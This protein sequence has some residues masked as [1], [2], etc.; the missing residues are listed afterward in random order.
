[1]QPATLQWT[2]HPLRQRPA[3]GALAAAIISLVAWAVLVSLHSLWLTVLAV[4]ILAIATAAF[5]LPTSYELNQRG[6]TEKRMGR[7]RFRNWTDFRR[8]TIGDRG[9]LLSP[10]NRAHWLERYRGI[11]LVFGDQ[12]PS[13]IKAVL[14]QHAKHAIEQGGRGQL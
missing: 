2:V 6:A 5:W 14:Q 11:V 10:F 9:A 8:V 1:M 4:V 7:A 12:D 3:D 13:S